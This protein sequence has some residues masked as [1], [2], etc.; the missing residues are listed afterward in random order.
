MNNNSSHWIAEAKKH[1]IDLSRLH[2][3]KVIIP[4]KLEELNLPRAKVYLFEEDTKEIGQL[5][6]K[7][8]ILL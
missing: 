8:I 7:N 3:D 4:K 6:K 5:F 1:G 2:Q